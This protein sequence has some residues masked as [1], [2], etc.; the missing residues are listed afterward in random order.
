MAKQQPASGQDL[1]DQE[2]VR[3]TKELAAYFRG[4]RTEREARGALKIIKAF[5]RERER[6]DPAKRRPLPGAR[7]SAPS[8]SPPK[9]KKPVSK[10]RRSRAPKSQ[11]RVSEAPP[12]AETS[13]E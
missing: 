2:V 9:R 13:P 10:K 12:A 1:R 7:S 4:L 8:P 11:P 3:A 6:L 5:I